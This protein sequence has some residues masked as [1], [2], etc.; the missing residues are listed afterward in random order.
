MDG[1]ALARGLE[2]VFK[3]APVKRQRDSRR[4]RRTK[5]AERKQTAPKAAEPRAEGEERETVEPAES[6]KP[7]GDGRRCHAVTVREY[8]ES[9]GPEPMIEATVRLLRVRQR[10]YKTEEAYIGW[11]RRLARFHDDKPMDEFGEEELKRFLS[12]IVVEEGVG[13]GTQRQAL[14]AGVFYLREV[15]KLELGDFSDRGVEDRR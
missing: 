8:Q 9:V 7:V 5:A 2:L 15:L 12:Y 11:L 6:A 14:N 3:N 13:A 4:K 10:S 1:A